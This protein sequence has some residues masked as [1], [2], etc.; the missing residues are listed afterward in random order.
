MLDPSNPDAYTVGWVCALSTEFTA[1]QEQFD[2]EYEPHESPEHRDANDFN[3]YSFGKIKGHMVVVAVLPNGQY[4]TAS[5]ATVAKDMIRSF[6][7]IRFGLMVGIG[8]GA[9][10]KQHDIR[11]GDVVVSSPTPGQSG[12]FQYD[13]GKAT[14]EVFQH[15]ASHNKP[16]PLLLA[17][18]AG[19][20]TQYERKGLQIHDKVSTIAANNKRLSAKYGRPEDPDSLF[21]PSIGHKSDPCHEFCVTAPTDLIDRIPRQEPMEDVEVHYGTIASGNTLMTDPFKRDELASKAN[22]L[23]FEME[24]AGLMDGFRCL[25]IRGICDYSDSHKNDRWQGYA[26]MTAAV[27]SKQ[28]LG[29]IRPEAVAREETI[30]SKIDEVLNS[31][32]SGVENL[33][34]SIAEQ[35]VL[36]WLSDEDFGT[37]QFDERSKKAPGTC[38]WF[39]GSPEYRSWIQGKGQVLFCPGIAGAGKTV[40]ASAIIENLHSRFQ[41]DSNIAIAH[42]YCRYNRVYKQTFNELQASLLR[43][44]CERLSPLPK[45][46]MKLHSEYKSR[47]V[48][49]PPERI[50]SGLESVSGLFS[51]V[52][53]VVDA[54]DEWQ[55]TEHVDLYSLPGELL[56]LQKKLTINLLT[57]SRPLPLISNQFG[58]CPAL[59]IIAQQQD[60]DAYIDNFRWPESSCIGKIPELRD[61]V[62]SIMSQ[63]VRGMFLLA[64]L[65]LHSLEHETSERDVKDALKRFGG[66]AKKKD[67]DPEFN[68]VDQ[69]YKDT[70]KR[71][72]EQHQ[73]HC[74]LAFRVL[75]WICC[76]SWRLPAGAIQHGLALR[77]GD[78]IFHEDGIVDEQLLLSICWGLVEISKGSREFR[79]VHYTTEDFF[80]HNRHLLDEYFLTQ[81]SLNCH[82]PSNTDAYLAR[83]CVTCLSIGLPVYPSRRTSNDAPNRYILL[84]T[85]KPLT[86]NRQPDLIDILESNPLYAYSALN[87]GGHV[88]RLSPLDQTYKASI[89]F[90][91]TRGMVNQAVQV[92]LNLLRT[93][94]KRS[95]EPQDTGALHLAS[96]FGLSDL[97]ESLMKNLDIDLRDGFGRTA[98]VWTLECLAFEYKLKSVYRR[99]ATPNFDIYNGIHIDRRLIV[100]DL[101]G[102]GANPNIAGYDGDTP[103]HLAVILGDVEIVERLFECGADIHTSNGMGNVPLVEAVRHDKEL[104]YMKLLERGTVNICGENSRTAL[105]EAASVGNLA[106]VKILFGKGA[107]VDLS[108]RTGQTALMEAS[109]LGHARIVKL[110]L[111]NQ[112][113]VDHQDHEYDTALMKAC[114]DDHADV[115]ELLLAADAQL[116]IIGRE[117]KTALDHGG[118][119]CGEDSIKRLLRHSTDPNIR[120]QHSGTVLISAS[121]CKRPDIVSLI[122]E[123]AELKP[124]SNFINLALSEAC[125]DSNEKVVR[126]LIDHGANPNMNLKARRQLTLLSNA[127]YFGGDAVVLTL[128][129]AGIDIET[130]D[131]DGKA[132]IHAAAAR[133]TKTMVQSL[134]ERG[135][136][137][138]RRSSAGLFPLDY[139]MRREDKDTSIADLLRRQG[140]ITEGKR[141]VQLMRDRSKRLD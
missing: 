43:Q 77:E 29:R 88:R 108:D 56:F 20:K 134:I 73:K 123:D 11:L 111:E 95:Q 140:A 126:L 89:N 10:T 104:V 36:A 79:L 119:Y 116:D 46:I 101:L 50:L 100:K 98:L 44:L 3:V 35:E 14:K 114:I 118:R 59:Q 141:L 54:L 64:R 6:R 136:S 23:C 28:I 48:E 66:R 110:L 70:L 13:F 105:I 87:W 41:N 133:G 51:K 82:L 122:L 40:L 137:V 24:A 12:V 7:N 17:A 96:L 131:G 113:N 130:E 90:L 53:L 69:A 42:I 57:T 21:S 91:Q 84:D 121:N 38:E 45:D 78:T 62:K 86:Y 5:A 18:V 4:G 22:I 27:Y 129:E 115:I 120:D 112:C 97:A 72:R 106:L 75:T 19:L 25:V 85:I 30:I 2:E 124:T 109:K 135:V 139:A 128:L 16:P 81:H 83:Q 102:S 67:N 138:N 9:P 26:A 93:W 61:M 94:S 1:A 117:R 47:R 80:R 32:I 37:Y 15:T 60:I 31:V 132:P 65:Y 103:L 52:F 39:L 127:I 55:A 8:G 68:I 71:L 49:A 74:D 92:V 58:N 76:T 33:K 107:K 34:R 63:V 125:S 99:L